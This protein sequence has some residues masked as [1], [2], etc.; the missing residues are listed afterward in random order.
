V[1]IV[2]RNV[3]EEFLGRLETEGYLADRLELPLLDQLQATAVTEDG[4]WIYPEN[5]GLRNTAVVGWWYGG[6]LQNVDLLS[7]PEP[8]NRTAGLRD[9]LMQMAWSGEL[10]GW[11]T[12]TPKWHLVAEDDVAREWEAALKEGLDQPIELVKPVANPELAG[13]TARRAAGADPNATLLPPEFVARYR[14]QF[15][16]RLWMRGL[17]AVLALYVMGLIIYF[18]ALGFLRYQ[19]TGAEQ[20]FANQARSYTNVIKLD[21][22]FKILK[23]RQE[24]KYAALDCWQ[25]VAETMPAGLTLDSMNFS[26]GKKLSIAGSAPADQVGAVIDFSDNL[27]KFVAR[28]QPLFSVGQNTPPKTSVMPGGTVRWSYELELKRTGE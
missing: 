7:L 3:V 25:A 1:L 14:Q 24:L 4:A 22:Q 28:G 16:D 23:Q 13:R 17:G 2:S 27:R 26:G 18:V 11:L 5:T 6:I 20:Q 19:T 10:E 15:I 12:G 8:A 9:Q 21:A